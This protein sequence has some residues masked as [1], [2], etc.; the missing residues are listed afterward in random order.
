MSPNQVE[1]LQRA[2]KREK[3]ARKAAEKILEEKSRDLYIAS[4]KQKQLLE[5]KSS[6]LQGVF[7]NIIDAYVVIDLNGNVIKFNDA[8]TKLFGYD[9]SQEALNVVSLIYKED[10]DYAIKSFGQLKTKGFFKD[11][12]ARVITRSKEVRWVHINASVIFDK[13]KKPIASQGVVRDITNQKISEEKLI[14]SENRLSALILNLHNG[15]LLE[16]ENRKIVLVNKK[17]CELFNIPVSPSL[18]IGQDCSNAAEQSKHKF[19]NPEGFVT[20]INDIL[21]NEKTVLADEVNMIN[22]RILERDFIPIEDGKSYRGHLWSYR[23]VTLNRTYRRSLEAQKQKYYNVIAN[24]NLGMVEID[25]NKEIVLVNQSFKRM[26]GYTDLEVKGKNINDFFI[27]DVDSII[28][29]QE[30]KKRLAGLS[31]SYQVKAKNKSGEV[32]DFLVSGAPNYNLDGEITGSIGILLDITK[33]K[34]LENQK[35]KLLSKLEKSNYELQEY[36]R[37]VSHDLKSPLHSI[38]ALVNWL[39]E[40][41]QGKL[42]EASLHNFGLIETTLEK[43]HQLI[44]GVLDYSSL[45]ADNNNIQDVDLNLLVK[46]LLAMLFIPKHIKIKVLK[47]LPVLKGN[48]IQLQ[49]LFQNLICNAVKFIDKEKGSIV[50]DVQDLKG[51]YKFSIKDNGIG[52]DEKFYDNIFKIFQTLNKSKNSSGIGLSIVKKIVHLH[53]GEIWLDSKLDVGTTFYFTLKKSINGTT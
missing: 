18:L 39:K 14:Q 44:V 38:Y 48:Q 35:E 37:I 5:E 26:S 31:S 42:D 2:L 23:D 52:I 30:Y 21:K 32:L 12:E 29:K 10:Y 45:G 43:M 6:Q 24:M 9:I 28:F 19:E 3:A 36:A 1:I 46:E 40:D 13:N 47:D 49:Q 50:I 11:Y 27:N 51:Y 15:V 17:F 34:N 25:N 8:A 22:G 41:N 7:E 33:I 16:D 53:E 4:K 20:R